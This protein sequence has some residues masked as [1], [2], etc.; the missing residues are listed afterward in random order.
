MATRIQLRRDTTANWVAENPIL[1][2]GEL[3][4]ETDTNKL[5]CG[6][7]T[8]AW[9]SLNYLSG[10]L[11]ID[12][13]GTLSLDASSSVQLPSGTTAQRPAS[14]NAGDLR[15]NTTEQT[16]EIWNGTV[17]GSVGGGASRDGFNAHSNSISTAQ[18]IGSG[19]NAVS[20]GPITI[21][22]GGSVTVPTGSTWTI[23]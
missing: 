11:Q 8:T 12:A 20:G 7:G 19:N 15:W 23:V 9:G 3:G 2:L 4:Y 5:K 10:Y 6:D 22:T 1:A 17:W 13:D 18:N 16:A 21:G 14:P